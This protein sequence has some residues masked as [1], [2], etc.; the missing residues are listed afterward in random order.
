MNS[1]D[2]VTQQGE[3]SKWTKNNNNIQFGRKLKIKS[4]N[5]HKNKTV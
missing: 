3:F 5:K 2:K 4:L 1:Q